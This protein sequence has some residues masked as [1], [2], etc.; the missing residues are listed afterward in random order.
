LKFKGKFKQR[1]T[2]G[3]DASPIMESFQWSIAA[4]LL[5]FDE[6]HDFRVTGVYL[7]QTNWQIVN[8]TLIANGTSLWRRITGLVE[9]TAIGMTDPQDTSC[10]G[11]VVQANI[12]NVI[13]FLSCGS[14]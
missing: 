14:Y 6:I 13:C 9:Q 2:G 10:N 1:W 5:V 12:I 11:Q 8:K 3:V 7:T 4:V